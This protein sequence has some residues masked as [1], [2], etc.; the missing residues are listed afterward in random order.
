[1]P[2]PIRSLRSGVNG[3]KV[4]PDGPVQVKI[5]FVVKHGNGSGTPTEKVPEDVLA[6]PVRIASSTHMI[7]CAHTEP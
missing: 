4:Y 1:V 6:M 7:R 5:I 2:A 3:C